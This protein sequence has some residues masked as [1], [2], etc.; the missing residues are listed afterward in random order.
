MGPAKTGKTF[1]SMAIAASLS[2]E[3]RKRGGSGRIAF[4]DSERESAKLYAM[5][6]AERVQYD[7]MDFEAGYAYIKQ[8]RKFPID[9]CELTPPFSPQSYIN[10]IED[11]AR[12][13]Y[14]I[15]VADSI[16]H[17]W[18]GSGGALDRKGKE[19]DRGSNSWTAW[20]KITPEHNSFVDSMLATPSHLIVTMRMKTAHAMETDEK[21]KVKI[22]E[23]GMEAIQRDGIEY[24]FTLIGSMDHNHVLTVTGSRLDGVIGAGDKF[25]RPGER[26]GAKIYG[27]VNDG[28]EPAPVAVAV[29]AKSVEIAATDQLHAIDMAMSE[30]E[31]TALLPALAELG[32]SAPHLKGEIRTR[33]DARKKWIK[34]EAEKFQEMTGP[35]NTVIGE[36]NFALKG[37]YPLESA[38][39]SSETTT[40]PS[41]FEVPSE[42]STAGEPS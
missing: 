36:I 27:W 16:S 15:T 28:D 34:K 6:R 7:G 29:P 35:P 13:G 31:L 10:V 24:E 12:E 9:V 19:E 8:I 18:A 42:G 30:S 14:D 33:Y 32:N 1:T 37:E 25:E 17:A 3:I 21:G 20:R 39:G 5:S 38:G 22:V 40:T 11:A 41:G 23:L 4:A 2:Y 26:L